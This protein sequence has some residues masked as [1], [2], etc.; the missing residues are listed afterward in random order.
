MGRSFPVHRCAARHRTQREQTTMHP[1]LLPKRERGCAVLW[2]RLWTHGLRERSG[3]LCEQG[4]RVTPRL[5]GT[6]H[7]S[8]APDEQRTAHALCTRL[9]QDPSAASCPSSRPALPL[10][11]P[12]PLYT[13]A[14]STLGLCPRLCG[15]A[16]MWCCELRKAW[17]CVSLLKILRWPL[18]EGGVSR[19]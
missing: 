3:P 8:P 6:Q 4:W 16:A 12:F 11:S 19:T 13:F 10:S 5:W 2:A 17:P 1:F 15:G 18:V 14:T 9:H 7:T